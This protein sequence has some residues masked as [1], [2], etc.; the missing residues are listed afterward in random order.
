ML[1]GY[2]TYIAAAALIVMGAWHCLVKTPHDHARCIELSSAALGL[3]GI[4]AKMGRDLTADEIK[5]LI[6]EARGKT[7]VESHKLQ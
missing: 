7:V 5:A 2:K 4:R 1:T 6:A 3:I